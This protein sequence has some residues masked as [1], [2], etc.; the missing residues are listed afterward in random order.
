MQYYCKISAIL[1]LE[2]EIWLVLGNSLNAHV[3]QAVGIV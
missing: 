1:F 2:T 3:A